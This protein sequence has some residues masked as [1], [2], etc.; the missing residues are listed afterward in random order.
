MDFIFTYE[1]YMCVYLI[2][3]LCVLGVFFLYYLRFGLLRENS[4]LLL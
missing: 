3:K 4:S 2:Q 1:N